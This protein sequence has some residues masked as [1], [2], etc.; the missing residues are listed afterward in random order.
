[1]DK[2][3]LINT[4]KELHIDTSLL[5]IEDNDNIILR[6]DRKYIKRDEMNKIFHCVKD[7]FPDNKVLAIPNSVNIQNLENTEIIDI[8]TMLKK[9]LEE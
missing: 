6:Y 8:I 9:M 4:L 2:E 5:R 3:I 7:M 1:M